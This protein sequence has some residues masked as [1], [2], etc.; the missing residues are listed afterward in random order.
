[1]KHSFWVRV[2]IESESLNEHAR[3][4]AGLRLRRAFDAVGPE[5]SHHAKGGIRIV[6]PIDHSSEI[7]D[8]LCNQ[9]NA[10]NAIE[11]YQGQI[12]ELESRVERLVFGYNAL[13]NLIETRRA[14]P[15]FL[16]SVA[17]NNAMVMPALQSEDEL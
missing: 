5:L 1:M 15:D 4:A 12:S 2:D 16:E 13:V 11:Y 6:D 17:R 9:V 10:C 7:A 14:A 8:L 3:E